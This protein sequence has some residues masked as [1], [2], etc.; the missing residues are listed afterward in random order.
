MPGAQLW[1]LINGILKINISKE[2]L[3]SAILLYINFM[4]KNRIGKTIPKFLSLSDFIYPC[5]KC[6]V[7][8]CCS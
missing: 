6:M 4:L 8:E 1:V 3:N 5:K 7:V 2:L